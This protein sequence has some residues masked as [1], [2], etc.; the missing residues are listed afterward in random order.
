MA[1]PL[2]ALCADDH[3]GQGHVP[4][5]ERSYG[6]DHVSDALGLTP[7]GPVNLGQIIPGFGNPVSSILVSVA[8]QQPQRQLY[9]LGDIMARFP[10]S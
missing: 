4:G 7:P 6:S 10:S 3:N 9:K 8:S 5:L 1:W 2:C